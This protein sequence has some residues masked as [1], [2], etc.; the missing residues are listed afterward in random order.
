VKELEGDTR[1]EAFTKS[2]ISRRRIL[3]VNILGDE[4]RL[5]FN[6]GTKL[7]NKK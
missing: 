1:L 7:K 4:K 6:E 5:N 2:T 3:L